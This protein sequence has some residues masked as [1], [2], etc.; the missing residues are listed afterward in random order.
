M[1]L[2]SPPPPDRA[3]YPQAGSP[4]SLNPHIYVNIRTHGKFRADILTGQGAWLGTPRALRDALA[5]LGSLTVTTIVP[6]TPRFTLGAFLCLRRATI[7]QDKRTARRLSM[8]LVV[9]GRVVCA[10]R[11]MTF[12]RRAYHS[13]SP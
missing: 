10:P 6:A 5:S 4:L 7:A 11:N 3:G 13:P 12:D 8:T 1:S 2:H 9:V